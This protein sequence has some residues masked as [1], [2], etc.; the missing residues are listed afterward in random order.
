VEEIVENQAVK[1]FKGAGA[2]SKVYG[3]SFPLIRSG[4][5]FGACFQPENG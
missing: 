3:I 4:K 2:G 5:V 1:P